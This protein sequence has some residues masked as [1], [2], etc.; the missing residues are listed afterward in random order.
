[1][2]PFALK[3]PIKLSLVFFTRKRRL[4]GSFTVY[5]T[6]FRN[7][8]IYRNEARVIFALRVALSSSGFFLLLCTFLFLGSM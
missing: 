4:L 7:D 1:M 5:S 8:G 3:N 2:T 6:H